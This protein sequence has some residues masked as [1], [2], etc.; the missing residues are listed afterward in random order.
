MSVYSQAIAE[1]R[2]WRRTRTREREAAK[3]DGD[4]GAEAEAQRLI[5]ELDQ[6]IE[7]LD[8]HMAGCE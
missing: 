2:K 3:A 4:R 5:N 8:L 6:Q 1:L 7:A